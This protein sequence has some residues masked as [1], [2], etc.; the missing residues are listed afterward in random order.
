M[1][2]ARSIAALCSLL[3][4]VTTT[5]WAAPPVKPHRGDD[6]STLDASS[7]QALFGHKRR[8]R[9]RRARRQQLLHFVSGRRNAF[10]IAHG[11]NTWR[12]PRAID[13]RGLKLESLDVQEQAASAVVSS[14]LARSAS[15][16]AGTYRVAIDDRIGQSVVLAVLRHGLLL[17]RGG[18][19]RYLGADDAPP[20]S[21]WLVWGSRYRVVVNATVGSS[22]SSSSRARRGSNPRK[23]PTR[24]VIRRANIRRRRR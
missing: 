14:K 15:C 16:R 21:F 19:L 20:P 8:R 5:S 24:R 22:S 3:C 18:A 17:E 6:A 1:S 9:N 11:S 12:Q 10:V 7:C 13:Y 23:R 2:A 4:F